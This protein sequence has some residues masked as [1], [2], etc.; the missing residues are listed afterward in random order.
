MAVYSSYIP[1]CTHV[2]SNE[3][4][5]SLFVQKYTLKIEEHQLNPRAYVDP[6]DPVVTLQLRL[7][8]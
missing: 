6:A 4:M 5:Q 3:Y 1:T 8:V 2:H 7:C